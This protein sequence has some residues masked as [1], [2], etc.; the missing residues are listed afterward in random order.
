M[1]GSLNRMISVRKFSI[2]LGT[3]KLVT[4]RVMECDVFHLEEIPTSKRNM[5]FSEDVSLENLI[6]VM[7][8]SNIAFKRILD[9][10]FTSTVNFNDL[11][12]WSSLDSSQRP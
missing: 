8:F 12:C 6:S 7:Q 9:A 5:S 4:Y 11:D 10:F 2:K 1:D 3:L